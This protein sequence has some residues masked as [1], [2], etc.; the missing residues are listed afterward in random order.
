M[1]CTY[2]PTRLLGLRW[3]EMPSQAASCYRVVVPL[4][5][6]SPHQRLAAP[7]DDLVALSRMPTKGSLPALPLAG[8]GISS[9]SISPWRGNF[10][11]MKQPPPFGPFRGMSLRTFA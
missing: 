3:L 8:Q 1:H 5:V 11:I 10:G 9:L 4:S 6:R 2:A 7:A